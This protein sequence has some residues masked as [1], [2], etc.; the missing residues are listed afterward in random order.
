MANPGLRTQEELR[1][2]KVSPRK[3]RVYAHITY[4]V[5]AKAGIG[6]RMMRAYYHINIITYASNQWTGTILI[7]Q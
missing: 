7:L 3:W 6:M 1:S 5:K 4:A 2:P